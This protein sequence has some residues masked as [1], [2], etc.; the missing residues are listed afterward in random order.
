M[1]E[2]GADLHVYAVADDLF[3]PGLEVALFSLR[4]VEASGIASI[5]VFTHARLSPL[6][7]TNAD[8]LR[9]L[10]GH[11]RFHDC[12]FLYPWAPDDARQLISLL[13]FESFRAHQRGT[14]IY[15]DSDILVLGRVSP[16]ASELLRS[17][18]SIA[19]IENTSWCE[20]WRKYAFDSFAMN[21]GLFVFH[22]ACLNLNK[23]YESF[24]REIYDSRRDLAMIPS[25]ICQPIFND[26]GSDVWGE[27]LAAP[28]YYNFRETSRFPGHREKVKVLHFVSRTT[29]RKKPWDLNRGSDDATRLWWQHRDMIHLPPEKLLGD[30]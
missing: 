19:G 26:V 11:V 2:T 5:N 13:K 21:A 29:L 3:F 15:I 7:K 17:G 25:M 23:A 8:R 1:G 12:T 6:S 18:L 4:N 22:D 20:D 28:M 24:C 30:A 27:Y 16:I 9:E 10:F 14:G